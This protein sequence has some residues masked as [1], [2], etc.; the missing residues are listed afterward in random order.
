[1]EN[2]NKKN[3]N[4]SNSLAFGRWPQTKIVEHLNKSEIN[5]IIFMAKN[6][7]FFKII[8]ILIF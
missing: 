7:L 8:L 6:I 1:M 5:W 2:N 4:S 3:N